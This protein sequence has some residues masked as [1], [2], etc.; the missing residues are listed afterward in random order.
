MFWLG[1]GKGKVRDPTGG[2]AFHHIWGDE[3][4]RGLTFRQ[5]CGHFISGREKVTREVR[6]ESSP[7]SVLN[8]IKGGSEG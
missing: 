2:H 4:S 8:L 5:Q 3:L 6:C 7:D 1:L